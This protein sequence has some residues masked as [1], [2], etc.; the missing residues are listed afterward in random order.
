MK[1]TLDREALIVLSSSYDKYVTMY[2]AASGTQLAK[3]TSGDITTAMG[4]TNNMRHLI[5]AS[6][7]GII[8]IWRLPEVLV[9]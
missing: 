8:Y 5:T 2:E 6:A 1:V 7:E 4:F 3:I 9:K